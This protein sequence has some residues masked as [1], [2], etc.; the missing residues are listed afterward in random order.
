MPKEGTS[1]LG[2]T[3]LTT[4]LSQCEILRYTARKGSNLSRGRRRTATASALVLAG[5]ENSSWT[6]KGGTQALV[7]LLAKGMEVIH[8][9]TSKGTL[10]GIAVSPF[11]PW[12]QPQEPEGRNS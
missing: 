10:S 9:E 4:R 1:D 8:Q 2:A 7:R 11:P 3:I 12:N 5:S 6:E